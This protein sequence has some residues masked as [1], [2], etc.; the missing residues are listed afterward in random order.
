MSPAVD[1]VVF[2]IGNVLL[3]WD[4]RILARRMGLDAAAYASLTAETALDEVN[5]RQLDAGRPYAATLAVLAKRFPRHREFLAA[6]D[7]RWTEMLDGPI[8]ANVALLAELR[9]ARFP[10]HAL[11]NFSAVKFELTRRLYPFLDG[12]DTR[13]ISGEIGLV[14]PDRDIF[15]HLIAASGLIPRR[16]VFIDD[17]APNIAAAD[18]LGFHTIHYTG[19]SVDVRARLV[20]LGLPVAD[21]SGG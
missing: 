15:D 17:S 21:R 5:H 10:V 3:R 8:D 7:T 12:F 11:S 20:A 9:G 2:D 16:A 18:A 1:C 19:A 13:I 6:W 14:K 4:P